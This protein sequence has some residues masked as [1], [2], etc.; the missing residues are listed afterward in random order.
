MK[1]AQPTPGWRLMAPTGQLFIQAPHSIQ[2]KRTGVSKAPLMTPR[3]TARAA[4]TPLCN[5]PA[6]EKTAGP[7]PDKRI[8]KGHKPEQDL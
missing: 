7:K 1:A 5:R 2:G 3:T 4:G 8:D 6:R